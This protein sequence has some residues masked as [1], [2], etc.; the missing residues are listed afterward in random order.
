MRA[1]IAPIIVALAATLSLASPTS[2]Q[3]ALPGAAGLQLPPI[4]GLVG[5]VTD[6][7][8]RTVDD[9]ER[10]TERQARNL[11]RARD[12]TLGRLLRDNPDTIALDRQGNLARRDE[13]LIQDVSEAGLLALVGAGFAVIETEQIEG[14]DIA[15][16]RLSLPAGLELAEAEALAA[17]LAPAA[18]VSADNLHLPAASSAPAAALVPL[19]LRSSASVS[20]EVGV[21]DGAAGSKVAT[22][23]QKGFAKGAPRA[24]DHGSAVASLLADAGARRI[25]VADVYGSDPA[26]GNALAIARALG[27]LTANGSKVVT[28]SLVGPRNSLLERA[29][30]AAQNKGVVVVAA[31]GNDGPAA[32]PAFPASYAGVVAITGVDAKGRA[33]I[34]AGRA[35]NLD[36]A[37]PGAGV[38]GY[39]RQGRRKAWRGTSFAAP[40]AA[41]RI[42]AALDNGGNWRARLDRE[43]RDL[44]AK[45]PDR[46]YGRGLVCGACGRR[47]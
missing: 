4:G 44:G 45:G 7:V 29:V 16:T 9:V 21:I 8:G 12:R 19:A 32:P 10:I 14:L 27:W 18:E 34:E 25:R 38:Y 26:G 36:Y 13:L 1:I 46:V 6:R 3:L 42:A 41:A 5:D 28:I 2:A 31:V 11:L 47:K 30:K 17:A 39:D 33:L 35:K 24:S 40:L 43:A 23:A 37:A 20:T 22:I 15:V